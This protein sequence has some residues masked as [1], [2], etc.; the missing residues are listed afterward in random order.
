MENIINKILNLLH[1]RIVKKT[2]FIFFPFLLIIIGIS[3]LF[4][5]NDYT[6]KENYL[7]EHEKDHIELCRNVILN[8]IL[9]IQSDLTIICNSQI[10]KNYLSE[11]TNKNQEQTNQDF[12]TFIS[13]KRFYDQLRLSIKKVLKKFE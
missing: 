13:K 7:F 11:K 5:V 10:F 6:N 8:N 4:Y 12:L 3:V 9:I 1:L 2:L